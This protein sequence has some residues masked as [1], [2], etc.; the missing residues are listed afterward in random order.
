MAFSYN[1]KTTLTVPLVG[2]LQSHGLLGPMRQLLSYCRPKKTTTASELQ[3]DGQTFAKN[4]VFHQ[5]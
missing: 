2:H 5:N 1:P 3:Y 4:P